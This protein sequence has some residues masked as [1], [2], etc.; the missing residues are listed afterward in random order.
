MKRYS[1]N[2]SRSASQ[3]RG[4]HSKIKAPNVHRQVMRGGYRL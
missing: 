2:K 4:K 1:V 3:F